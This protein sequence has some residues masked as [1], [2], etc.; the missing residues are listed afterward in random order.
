MPREAAELPWA[1]GERMPREAAERA[2]P[3]DERN[4]TTGA[5]PKHL[6]QDGGEDSVSEFLPGP[7][8]APLPPTRK[9]TAPMALLHPNTDANE[10]GVR[11]YR[12]P[13]DGQTAVTS[14]SE[15]LLQ[16]SRATAPKQATPSTRAGEIVS[17]DDAELQR[18]YRDFIDTKQACGES[19]AGLT[20]DRFLG[21]LRVNR[22]QLIDRF[23]CKTVRFQVYVKDG[24]AA[25][26][27][28]PVSS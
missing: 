4:L 18:V 11:S 16:A 19:I 23:A 9:V 3:T 5:H 26:K 22:Q 24:K 1:A 8:G 17:N 21:K 6:R 14:P 27:A 15:I 20:Y 13:F 2:L 25:L 12:D 10:H 7:R 28:T